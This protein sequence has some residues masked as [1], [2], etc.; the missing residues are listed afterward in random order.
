MTD[1]QFTQLMSGIAAIDEKLGV[2]VRG[3]QA[4]RNSM[5]SLLENLLQEEKPNV[6]NY[7]RQRLLGGPGLESQ[8]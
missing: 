6:D 5:E 2:M 4:D 1:E 3:A 7:Y 8:W